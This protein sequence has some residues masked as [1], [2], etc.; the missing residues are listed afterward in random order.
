MTCTSRSTRGRVA[1]QVLVVAALAFLVPAAHATG[2]QFSATPSC[3]VITNLDGTAG[4]NATGLSL[5]NSTVTGIKG[6]SMPTGDHDR[7][8][9]K[10]GALTSGSLSAGG[11]FSDTG[12]SLEITGTYGPITAGTIFKGAFTGP[13]SWV[14]TSP[15]NCKTCDYTLTGAIAGDW[16]VRGTNYTSGSIVQID[17]TSNG[18]Y[19]GSSK[20]ALQDTGGVT[21]LFGLPGSAVVPEPSSLTLM[22]TGLMG[23]GFALRRK[24]RL[25]K[26]VSV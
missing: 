12:S 24:L 1:T 13:I 21:E 16:Y 3:L 4:G 11:M 25:S 15:S 19:T 6:A 18:L 26:R 7:L 20:N 23:A 10:T 9:F 22:G 14:L 2:C 8:A 17:F 5:T